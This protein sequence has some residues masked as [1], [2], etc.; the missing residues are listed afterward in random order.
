MGMSTLRIHPY[1][2]CNPRVVRVARVMR[3]VNF[4]GLNRC[5][6]LADSPID[7]TLSKGRGR[8]CAAFSNP[9]NQTPNPQKIKINP[10]VVAC[11][12]RVARVVRV[13]RVWWAHVVRVVR[14]A[15]VAQ[16]PFSNTQR[17]RL[18]Q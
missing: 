18:V 5:V 10:R 16:M 15:H 14:V 4:F 11:G 2:A 13:W 1:M 8:V 7:G 17:R 6:N 9:E 3:L 12:A